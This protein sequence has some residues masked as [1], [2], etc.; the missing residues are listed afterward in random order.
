MEIV[1]TIVDK[2][3]KNKVLFITLLAYVMTT[4]LALWLFYP[5]WTAI[6]TIVLIITGII[7]LWYTCETMLLREVSNRQYRLQLRPFI[8]AK[9]NYI[10]GWVDVTNIGNG[11]ALNVRVGNGK[12]S[13]NK[14][15]CFLNIKDSVDVLMPNQSKS[16]NTEFSSDAG[17]DV[18]PNE[19]FSS[20]DALEVPFTLSYDD[21]DLGHYT[22]IQ[23]KSKNNHYGYREFTGRHILK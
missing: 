23:G 5:N 2:I 4:V 1:D 16:L 9:Y 8:I 13:H 21:C 10:N 19:L 20:L 15:T 14:H 11:V 3:S 18:T 17:K 12:I 7:V 22:V 6:Q